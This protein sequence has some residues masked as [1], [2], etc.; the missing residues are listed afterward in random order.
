MNGPH[1]ILSGLSVLN[2]CT[3]CDQPAVDDPSQH[4]A[5]VKLSCILQLQ[6]SLL[7]VAKSVCTMATALYKLSAWA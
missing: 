6:S 5:K 3:A 4:K 1:L 2:I 7:Q